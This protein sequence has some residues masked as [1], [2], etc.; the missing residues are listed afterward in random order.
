MRITGEVPP[1]IWNR[2]GT[3]ILPKLRLGRELKIGIDFAVT[4]EANSAGNLKSEIQQVLADL[5]LEGK[6]LID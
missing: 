2:L 4:V 5:N 6:V 1:E 3:K